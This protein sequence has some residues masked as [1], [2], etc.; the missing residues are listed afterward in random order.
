MTDGD[1]VYEIAGVRVQV[2]MDHEDTRQ[3]TY[4]VAGDELED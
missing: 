2:Y 1:E 4:L 3:T